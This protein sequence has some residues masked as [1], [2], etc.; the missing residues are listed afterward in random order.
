MSSKEKQS[1]RRYTAEF[2]EQAVKRVLSGHAVTAVAGE[3]G[4]SDS[5]I[6]NWLA[7]HRQ[8]AGAGAV[9]AEQAAEIA[10]LKRLLAQREEEVA[11]LKK[12]A[13]YVAKES[14]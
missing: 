4:V 10:R 8:Q 3:L 2:K 12:A 13:A 11:M 5:L 1:R 7:R 9:Q 14:R 6:H